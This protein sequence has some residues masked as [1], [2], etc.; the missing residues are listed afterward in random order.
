MSYAAIKKGAK[1]NSAGARFSDKI[2]N[3]MS[4][5]T[6]RC[7]TT[8][9]D[10]DLI[11]RT[12]YEVYRRRNMIGD[13]IDLKL[14]D[15]EHDKT[16]NALLTMTSIGAEF[17]GT[18]RVHVG[19]NI[20]DILPSRRVF[21][22]LIDPYLLAGVTVVDP[23]RLAAR[24]EASKLYPELPFL[25]LRPAWLAAVHF[26]ADIVLA[27][28]AV[29]HVPFY[30]RVFGYEQLCEP[31]D[32]PLLSFKVACLAL[33]F[34]GAQAAVEARYPFFRST[35]AERQALFGQR[36]IL[37]AASLD[38]SQVAPVSAEGLRSI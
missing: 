34:P 7:A 22:D 12:R 17:V 33:G 13:R 31:R 15:I 18:F 28:V 32:Y 38:V 37:N 30:R 25:V 2:V 8:E 16:S 35:L 19:R 1:P 24:L 27:T 36:P 6:H 9:E 29:E 10:L 26:D 5:V 21:S 3:L 4:S 20:S 23:T 14:Y 11:F